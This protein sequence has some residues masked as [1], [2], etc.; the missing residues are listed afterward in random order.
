MAAINP[1]HPDCAGVRLPDESMFPSIPYNGTARRALTVNASGSLA[2][3]IQPRISATF[4]EALPANVNSAGTISSWAGGTI[5]S[6]TNY[7]PVVAQFDLFRHVAWGVRIIGNS[8]LTATSGTLYGAYIPNYYANAVTPT[9]W[10]TTPD[11]II[12][13]PWSVMIPVVDLVT[14]AQIFPAKRVDIGSTRYRNLGYPTVGPDQMES[15]DGWGSFIFIVTGG[16]AAASSLQVEV[17]Y[18]TEMIPQP[19]ASVIST[20]SSFPASSAEMDSVSNISS[21]LPMSYTETSDPGFFEGVV[22]EAQTR[23]S[24][25]WSSYGPGLGR[26]LVAGAFRVGGAMAT[27][28]VSSL[29]RRTNTRRVGY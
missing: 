26:Q 4:Y 6:M 7:A 13:L 17:V 5:T 8:S 15:S 16:G 2:F 23:M 19:T 10:P 11:Q 3:A 27:N 29:N 14:E 12:A 9:E 18:R 22:L 25:L 28:Y 1:F 20:G 21:V 24:N